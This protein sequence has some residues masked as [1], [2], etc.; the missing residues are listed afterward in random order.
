MPYSKFKQWLLIGALFITVADVL[1]MFSVEVPILFIIGIGIAL[2][3]QWYYSYGM[4][5]YP[6]F[7][8]GLLFRN[9]IWGIFPLLYGSF[10]IYV[11][12][13][14]LGEFQFPIVLYTATLIAT[15]FSAINM[16]GRVKRSSAILL[17]TGAALY[18][19]SDSMLA[20]EL[21]LGEEFFIPNPRFW[22]MLTYLIGIYL[23]LQGAVNASQL[24]LNVNSTST[25]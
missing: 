10:I 16:Q 20:F 13:S 5:Q 24:S 6:D 2:L 1:L 14:D 12:W 9:P 17:I 3:G 22:I 15:V 21:F 18:M 25:R 23:M 11:L 19:L 7:R 4:A 8:E